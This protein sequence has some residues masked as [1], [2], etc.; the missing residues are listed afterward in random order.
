MFKVSF[1]DNS[2]KA[3]VF[4][5]RATIV[6][7]VGTMTFP[8]TLWS[9]F[10]DIIANWMWQHPSVDA[11]WSSHN[12]N[13][14]MEA[15]RLE[16]SG[17]SVCAEEDTFNPIIGERIAESRAKIKLY[18]FLHNLCE[19]LMNHYYDIMYGNAEIGTIR[20]SHTEAPKDCLYLPCQKY[21]EL[22]I[23]ESRHLGKLLE[24]A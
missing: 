8:T 21:R 19:M 13:L 15:I 14:N 5:N 17:K 22:W 18:K 20:E 9:V 16:V 7:L 12:K 6:T 11:S 24:E 4:N 1:K 10:P 2:K 3:Q 23:K